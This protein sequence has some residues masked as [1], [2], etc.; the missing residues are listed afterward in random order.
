MKRLLV[1]F[2]VI[3]LILQPLQAQ[4]RDSV[5]TASEQFKWQKLITPGALMGAGVICTLSPAYRTHV[6]EP[7]R[8]WALRMSGG[9]ERPFDNYLQYA[10]Y[11]EY[12]LGMAVGAGEHG[13]WEQLLA[14]GTAILVTS[15]MSGSIKQLADVTRPNDHFRH[16]SFPSGHTVTAFLA[17]ELVRLEF[18]PWW[19]LAAYSMAGVT[20]FMRIYNNWHWTSDLLGGAAVGI[21]GANIGYWLLPLERKWVHLDS[22]LASSGVQASALP[23]VAPTPVGS[24]YGVS[25]ALSF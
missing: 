21:L 20:A 5:Y 19:G 25:L 11:A 3:T 9:T 17:A 6:N 2:A 24:C 15:A 8:D 18:G 1:L 12:V 10:G 13:P 4:R 22:K 7:V 23:Y 14:V 16:D